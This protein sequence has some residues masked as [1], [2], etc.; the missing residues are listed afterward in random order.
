MLN[1]FK[2]N[3]RIQRRPWFYPLISTVVAL[4]I[5][6]TAIPGQAFSWTDLLTQGVQLVQLSTMSTQQEVDMGKQINQQ[7][8]N[9]QI[10]LYKNSAIN[11]YVESVGKRLAANSDRPN[12]PY[13]FQIVDDNAVNAFATTGGFVYVNKGLLKTAANEAELASVI[14]HEIGHIGGKH[15]MKQM[16][17]TALANGVATVAGVNR[18][19][20]VQ[21]GM[22]LALNLP[23]SRKDEFEADQRGLRTI[24]RSGY[25]QSAMVSFMKKLLSKGSV[26][27]F[28]SNHPATGDRIIAL[29][30]AIKPVANNIGYGVDDL[31]YQARMAAL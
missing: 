29:Q 28:L 18:N 7:L 11:E 10:K 20:L 12:L 2:A 23:H 3:F 25:N 22:Q 5:F 24:G 1:S 31:T 16:R 19:Q 14:G 4:S 9:G 8:V 30:R 15:L 27:A 26:P 21:L 17:S 6:G 13:T